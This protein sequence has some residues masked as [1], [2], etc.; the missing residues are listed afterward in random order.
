MPSLR[1]P[2]LIFSKAGI[3]RSLGRD[4]TLDAPDPV[5][6]LVRVQT[7]VCPRKMTDPRD[8]AAS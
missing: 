5:P 7:L 8:L 4:L 1:L 3:P 2:S 6:I